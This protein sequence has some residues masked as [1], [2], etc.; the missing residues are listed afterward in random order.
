MRIGGFDL[1]RRGPVFEQFVRAELGSMKRLRNFVVH[2]NPLIITVNS[3]TEEVDVL[4]RLG[5]TVIVGEVKCSVFPSEPWEVHNYY[6]VLKAAAEQAQRKTILAASGLPELRK[7]PGFANLP[8]DAIFLPLVITNLTLGSGHQFSG[9]PV[10][11][12]LILRR[13]FE[14]GHLETFGY[15][16]S[17][18]NRIVGKDVQFYSDEDDAEA[19]LKMYFHNPPQV[20]IFNRYL[21]IRSHPLLKLS[22]DDHPAAYVEIAVVVPE[23]LPLPADV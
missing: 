12:M 10:S 5:R 11:D 18:G 8:E 9:V 20:T 14:E 16:D 23:T 15:I 22:D 17:Q 6:E 19:Q 4:A 2:P 13:Y 7:L 3:Q 1:E 21:D